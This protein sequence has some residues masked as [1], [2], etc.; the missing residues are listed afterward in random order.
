MESSGL[1][2]FGELR[3]HSD[4]MIMVQETRDLLENTAIS[5]PSPQQLFEFQ[6]T[7]L[8][9]LNNY[10]HL[11]EVVTA[12]CRLCEDGFTE[13]NSIILTLNSH[14]HLRQLLEHRVRELDYWKE[15]GITEELFKRMRTNAV[16]LLEKQVMG[17]YFPELKLSTEC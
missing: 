4:P 16:T 17:F 10:H 13:L 9:S 11:S 12:A 15:G 2:V 7:A 3:K 1:E 14:D 6:Q 8:L 5:A